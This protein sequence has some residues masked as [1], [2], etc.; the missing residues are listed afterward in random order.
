MYF[1]IKDVTDCGSPPVIPDARVTYH[2]TL[3]YSTAVYTCNSGFRLVGSPIA[4][5]RDTAR[6]WVPT[7][8]CDVSD[9]C[10]AGP[11]VHDDPLESVSPLLQLFPELQFGCHGYIGRWWFYSRASAR[12]V[13]FGV[14]RST[15][16]SAYKFQL[17][18]SNRI[19]AKAK[20]MNYARIPPDEMIAVEPGVR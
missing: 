15:P 5:C 17:V 3:A 7:P 1:L 9:L 6:R 14:W 18:G 11:E 20:G 2:S 13:Y 4:T 16:E 8:L 10:F 19:A 12:T